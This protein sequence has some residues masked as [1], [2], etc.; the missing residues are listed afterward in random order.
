M[1]GWQVHLN[2]RES[3]FVEPDSN[4]QS[5]A[6]QDQ[7]SEGSSSEFD[8][9]TTRRRVVRMLVVLLIGVSLI[10]GL[11]LLGTSTDHQVANFA[12]GLIALI[13]GVILLFQLHRT[14][15]DFG[16]T[17]A[18][19]L[20]LLGLIAAAVTL[21]RFDGFSGEMVPLFKLRFGSST[22][23]VRSLSEASDV[24]AESVADGPSAV[25]ETDF[26][27]FLGNSRTGVIAE[28]EF[29]VPESVESVELL[30]N[31]GVGDGWSS[32]AVVEDRAITLEQRDQDECLTCYRLADGE[33]MWVIRHTAIHQNPMG[34]IGPRS[35]PSID[36]D[37][38]YAQGATGTLWCV[39]WKTGEERWSVDL[40]DLAGWDQAASEGLISWG[41]AGSPLLVEGLCVIPYGGPP[42]NES[43]GRSLIALAADT[44][45][46]RWI[47]G[48]DQISYASPCLMTLA[49]E[50]QIVSVNEQTI[51]GHR[52]EDGLELWQF[53]WYGQSN[54][55]ANCSMAV[56]AGQDRFLIGK[57]YGGGS[58][59]VEVSKADSGSMTAQA[60][61]Q[62]SR[63]LKTKFT[64]ACVDGDTAYAISNGS[65]EAVS[66]PDGEQLWRQPRGGRLGQGQLLLVGDTLLGQ[67]E[68]GEVVFIDANPNEYRERLRLPAMESKTWN[69]P[70]IA[71]R[72][73]L[74]RNDRQAFCFLLPPAGD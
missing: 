66:I 31:Q 62:S 30:W 20:A 12:S 50:R 60:V 52:I 39:N 16:A 38:V 10:T 22:P 6:G 56:P 5:D 26:L 8:G 58:A 53:E 4:Q 19:P 35:T 43:T 46:T 42:E 70:T 74:V 14:A 41:R 1:S 21:F 68:S 51:T 48:A 34:G 64:H 24:P 49:G 40:L 15:S 23:A 18:V 54:S 47:A 61:W 36:G 7:A 33:L 73:L 45:Q 2:P 57:G 17:R 28:R 59:L 32:F 65:L 67:S 71:G 72:H 3:T 13:I 25:A 27:G 63:V 69:I 55:G 11:Q 37:Y 9:V 44:G 29:A